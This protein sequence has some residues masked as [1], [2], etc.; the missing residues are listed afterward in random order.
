MSGRFATMAFSMSPM[1]WVVPEPSRC[2]HPDDD[3]RIRHGFP[4]SHSLIPIVCTPDRRW[5]S[6]SAEV[7]ERSALS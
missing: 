4:H 6:S 1:M 5:S 3:P 2:Y 7:F